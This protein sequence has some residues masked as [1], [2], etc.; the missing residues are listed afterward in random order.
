MVPLRRWWL[1]LSP[2][3]P[4]RLRCWRRTIEAVSFAFWNQAGA[5]SE[6]YKTPRPS[7]EVFARGHIDLDAAALDADGD[8]LLDLVIVGTQLNPFYD[9]WFVQL[10][11]NRGD[12]T[13]ADETALR[14]Q[15]QEQSSGNAGVAANA[16]WARWVDVLDFNGDGAADFVMV[17]NGDDL[18]PNQPLIWLNDGRGRFSALKVQDFVRPGDEWLLYGARLV[19]TRHGYSYINLQS[20]PGSGG[21]TLTGLLA[22]RPYRERLPSANRSPTSVGVLPDRAMPP[23]GMLGLDVALAFVDP[24]G[25]QLTYTVSSSAPQVVT[26][27]AAGAVVT[28]TAVG[29]GTAAIRVTAVDP[30]GLSATQSFTV[31]VSTAVSGSFTDDPLQPG[32]TPVRAVH[33]AELRTRI[34][35]LRGAGGLPARAKV[36][37]RSSVEQ[38]DIELGPAA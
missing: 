6:Q 32:V 30:G 9:G 28:L 17:T 18:P 33:F 35:A 12:G 7:P 37:E 16:P 36:A 27:R 21:L 23:G 24:D 25:D 5:F 14:L 2:R 3:P 8:G 13:F 11:M 29:E 22:T 15:P 34:D 4:L 31:T 20:F 10:L 26:A 19:R 1:L 38:L